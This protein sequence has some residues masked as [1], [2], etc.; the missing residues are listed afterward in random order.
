ML[1]AVFVWLCTVLCGFLW[2]IWGDSNWLNVLIKWVLL[3]TAV[4]GII[5]L[6]QN[7]GFFALV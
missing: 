7:N 5:I 4:C 6:Y 3:V 1:I 2:T